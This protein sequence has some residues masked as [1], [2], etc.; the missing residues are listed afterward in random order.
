MVTFEECPRHWAFRY[1]LGLSPATPAVPGRPLGVYH[2]GSAAHAGVAAHYRGDNITAAVEGFYDQLWD[3]LYHD[4]PDHW[5]DYPTW[6]GGSRD[7]AVAVAEGY[8]T[9]AK[10]VELDVGLTVVAIEQTWIYDDP[11]TGVLV[12]GTWD[13]VVYDHMLQ[14]YRVR[15]LKTVKSEKELDAA[16]HPD[17]LQLS[18]YNWALEEYT[19]QLPAGGQ[20]VR[21]RRVKQ[22]S[23]RAKSRVY[24]LAPNAKRLS[25]ADLAAVGERVYHTFHEMT[26]AYEVATTATETAVTLGRSPL[27]RANP[28]RD[29]DW[30][31]RYNQICP[32]IRDPYAQEAMDD[33]FVSTYSQELRPTS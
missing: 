15:D 26:R 33:F 30:K 10:E 7:Y 28:T 4:R 20:H 12:V 25:H 24:E 14:R 22:P 1:A 21:A 27:T 19:G 32:R 6:V 2:I 9:W 3:S 8:P 29:C 16:I 11:E 13:Q 31:C 5:K 18:V 23:A 17:N